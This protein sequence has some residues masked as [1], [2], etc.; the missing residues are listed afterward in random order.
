[1][2]V[3]IKNSSIA[4]CDSIETLGKQG[5]RIENFVKI[6]L[7]S[8]QGV[9]E[10]M[11]SICDRSIRCVLDTG[12]T[13]NLMN[14]DLE[15]KQSFEQTI[16]D[17]KNTRNATIRI[18]AQEFDSMPFLHIPIKTPIPIDAVLGMTFFANHIVFIDFVNKTIY[19]AEADM[20]SPI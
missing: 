4:I 2:L 9:A 10:F 12:C 19:L 13:L 6:P 17:E 5:Y 20:V 7:L 15:D 8:N 18:D 14:A 16:W 11:A 1:V 3:D